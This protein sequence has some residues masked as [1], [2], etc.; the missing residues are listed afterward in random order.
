MLG[1]NLGE[2]SSA[3]LSQV[4]YPTNTF[5]PYFVSMIVALD[6]LFLVVLGNLEVALYIP[7]TIQHSVAFLWLGVG[8]YGVMNRAIPGK[9]KEAI[10]SRCTPL[11]P[12]S[13]IEYEPLQHPS[14]QPRFLIPV[15][16]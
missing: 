11:A 16:A 13:A 8:W 1:S 14:Q 10:S 4:S 7:T 2:T 3:Q 15:K 6:V 12:Q 5:G 9:K